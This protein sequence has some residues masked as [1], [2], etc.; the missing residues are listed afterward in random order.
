MSLVEF[1]VEYTLPVD[2]PCLPGHFPGAPVVP[3]VVLLERVEQALGAALGAPARL[4]GLPAVKFMSP[5]LPG[6][7]FAI[8]LAIDPA[9]RGA[10]FRILAR[11]QERVQ[12]RVE[13]ALAP[14]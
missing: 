9:A 7:P 11:G 6:V 4:R 5:V 3:A 10:R 12:G 2:H 8:E 14:P 1:R 13:Y